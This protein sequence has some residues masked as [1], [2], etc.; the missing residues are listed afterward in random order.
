MTLVITGLTHDHVDG[1]AAM[2]DI[3]PELYRVANKEFPFPTAQAWLDYFRSPGDIVERFGTVTSVLQSWQALE[4]AGYSYGIFRSGQGYRYVEAKFAP[5]YH[6]NGGLTLRAVTAAMI[7]GFKRAERETGIR[8]FPVICIGREATPEL[9]CDVAR[10]ALDYD[11]EVALDLVCDEA[12]HTPEKHLPAYQLTFDSGVRRDCHAGEWVA[13]TIGTPEYE[14]L[15]SENV[16][17]AITK[18]RC[19]SVGHAITLGRDYDL[20][21]LVRDRGVRVAGC[22]LSNLS[23]KLIPD[24][25]YLCID[26]IL[27][28]GIRYTISADDDL[29]MPPMDQVIRQVQ[30]TYQFTDREMAVLERNVYRGA[31]ASDVRTE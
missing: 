13:G 22:P 5:Q 14:R 23:S 27:D 31:L 11:S 12:N 8:I 15:L 29:F 24:L 28:M 20:L 7:Q 6:T 9:G 2:T 18:L 3:I 30:R 26:R 25:I 19:H 21:L 16:R 10:V 1:S 4:L 17:T